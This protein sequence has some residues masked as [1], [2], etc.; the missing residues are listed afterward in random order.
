MNCSAFRTRL[1]SLPTGAFD[2]TFQGRPYLLTIERVSGGKVTK[3]F[4]RELGGNDIVSGN[5]FATLKEGLLKP[6]EMSEEKV[7][8]FILGMQRCS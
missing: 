7:V 1:L 5:Y 2:V 4:A 6:C 8:D 3:L